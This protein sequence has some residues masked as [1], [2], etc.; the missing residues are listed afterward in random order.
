MMVREIFQIRRFSKTHKP[1]FV[2]EEFYI[3][4]KLSDDAI[5]IQKMLDPHYL[6]EPELIIYIN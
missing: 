2:K 4:N 6:S 5:W 1:F 3:I